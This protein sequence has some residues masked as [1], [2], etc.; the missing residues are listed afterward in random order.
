MKRIPQILLQAYLRQYPINLRLSQFNFLSRYSWLKNVLEDL[1]PELFPEP[2]AIAEP[3]STITPDVVSETVIHPLV[4]K[5]IQGDRGTYKIEQFCGK[6][7]NGLLF[8]GQQRESQQ[9]VT[10]KV[11][12]LEE[13]R[14]NE[15]EIR[16]RQRAFK[17]LAGVSLADGRVQDFRVLIPIEAIAGDYHPI[18]TE[19]GQVSYCFLVTEAH[20]QQ[21][22]LAQTL[23][24]RSPLEVCDVLDQVLQTLAF[25]HQQRYLLPSGQTQ[26]GVVHGNLTLNSL[27]WT[28]YGDCSFTYLTDLAVWE[29]FFT[30]PGQRWETFSVEVTPESVAN[31]LRAVGLIALSLLNGRVI[32]TVPESLDRAVWQQAPPELEQFIRRL[33]VLHISTPADT[34]AELAWQDLLKIRQTL[35]KGSIK[36]RVEAGTDEPVPEVTRRRSPW[37][38]PLLGVTTLAVLGGV[39]WLFWMRPGTTASQRLIPLTCCLS[40]VSALPTGHFAYTAVE[41]GTWSYVLHQNNLLQRKQTLTSAL[42]N[43]QPNLQLDYQPARSTAEAIARVQSR[44]ADFAVLPLTQPLPID[45]DSQTIAYDGIA[46]LVSFSYSERQRGLPEAL[47]GEITLKEVRSLY[48]GSIASWDEVGGSRLPTQLYGSTNPDAQQFFAQVLFSNTSQNINPNINPNTS[49]TRWPTTPIDWKNSLDLLRQIIRDFESVRPPIGSVGFAPFSEI[50]GQ[51]SIYPLAISTDQQAA[52]QPLIFANGEPIT[53]RT[54][55]CD[56]KGDYH[57]DVQAFQSGRYPLAYAIAVVYPRDNSRSSI[58]QKFA[59]LMT[60]QEGQALLTAAGLIPMQPMR[61]AQAP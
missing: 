10:I 39:A 47:K 50:A 28:N 30:D 61:A 7:G 37:L 14:Y 29:R 4:G 21:P 55:L 57:P 26:P 20:D 1:R 54:D 9:P 2:E 36:V 46:I 15:R 48:M 13:P 40:E 19:T 38:L 53:P 52:V 3:P 42:T 24:Q 49:F 34:Q 22:S 51:C 16:E 59:E 23:S 33:F 35:L 32:S 45:L 17:S 11:Y 44:A 12:L 6:R 8:A 27:L 5:I 60:T 41:N 56:R 31:D 18:A 58:G 43:A 25:L